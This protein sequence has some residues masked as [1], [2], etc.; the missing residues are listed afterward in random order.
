M[1]DAVWSVGDDV[2]TTLIAPGGGTVDYVR[3]LVL[4]AGEHE[5]DMVIHPGEDFDRLCESF[6]KCDMKL[7]DLKEGPVYVLRNVQNADVETFG[8]NF[9]WE[10]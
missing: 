8:E 1:S 7:E 10:Q 4:H 6:A 5:L 3:G 2:V 9:M